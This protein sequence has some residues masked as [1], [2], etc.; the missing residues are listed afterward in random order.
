MVQQKKEYTIYSDMHIGGPHQK[1]LLRDINN[2]KFTKNTVFIGDNFD[3]QHSQKRDLLK[4]VEFRKKV[5]EKVKEAGGIFLDGNHELHPLEKGE[6]HVVRDNTIFLHGD[7]VHWGFKK[8]KKYRDTKTCGNCDLAW[9]LLLAYRQFFDG[10]K[11]SLKKKHIERAIHLAKK[12]NCKNIVFGHF[13]PKNLIVIMKD[14]VRI[15][16]V[17]RGISRIEL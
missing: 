17:P 7:I 2:T 9:G 1:N 15:I 4:V 8:A 14:G 16:V 10:G 6:F 12:F 11:E 3:F 5:E 13:H